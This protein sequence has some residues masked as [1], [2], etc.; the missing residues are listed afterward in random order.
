MPPIPPGSCISGYRCSTEGSWESV[1]A[2][3]GTACNDHNA[4]TYN[5]IC[6]NQRGTCQGSPVSCT[7]P[8]EMCNGT[9]TCAPRAAGTACPT[10]VYLASDRSPDPCEAVCDGVSPY[11]QPR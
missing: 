6:I 11:C 9:A 7:R 8:C 10:P 3:V 5:D 4:C 2:P 1:Y